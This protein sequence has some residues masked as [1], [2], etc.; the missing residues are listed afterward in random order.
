MLLEFAGRE[1]VAPR[2]I[3]ISQTE[4]ETENAM[5][6]KASGPQQVQPQ[7]LFG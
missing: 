2:E 7:T 6:M 4:L 3:Q 5:E 1:A